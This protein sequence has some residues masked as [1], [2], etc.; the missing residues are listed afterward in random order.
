M[1]NSNWRQLVMV[2]GFS[3]YGKGFRKVFI[4]LLSFL[5]KWFKLKFF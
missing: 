4:G 5:T 3:T 1:V 2:T